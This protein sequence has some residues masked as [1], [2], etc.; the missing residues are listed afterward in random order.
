MGGAPLVSG[1]VYGSA[2]ISGD[3]V[4]PFFMNGCGSAETG[5]TPSNCDK[6]W[7]F[8]CV[9]PAGETITAASLSV[10]LWDLDSTPAGN[11]IGL[12]Q[13]NGGD[14]LTF[15]INTASEALHGGTGSLNAEYDLFTFA[16]SSFGG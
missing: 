10:G 14:V 5:E 12:Y 1:S 11:Q 9:I 7:T 8:N 6:S 3:F 2:I 15:V 4:A 13:I 16:L